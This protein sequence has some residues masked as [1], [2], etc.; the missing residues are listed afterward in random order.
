MKSNYT[1][2][3]R[4]F[5]EFTVA[6]RQEG[7]MIKFKVYDGSPIFLL[8][9][10]PIMSFE[11]NAFYIL[12]IGGVAKY[13]SIVIERDIELPRKAE[14]AEH[15]TIKREIQRLSQGVGTSYR[16]IHGAKLPEGYSD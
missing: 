4:Y 6:I 14:N 13:A 9:A 12:D 1:Y 2:T 16:E 3:S 15:T 7:D 8:L 10:R 5:N 11:N